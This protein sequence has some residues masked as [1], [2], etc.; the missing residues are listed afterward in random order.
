MWLV[1]AEIP[2]V[3]AAGAAASAEGEQRKTKKVVYENKK[4]KKPQQTGIERQESDTTKE[5]E[6][7]NCLL[8]VE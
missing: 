8:Y 1:G 6:L 5:G 4:K 2:A 7:F 3:A